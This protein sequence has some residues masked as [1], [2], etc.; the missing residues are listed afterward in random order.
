MKN[1]CTPPKLAP[2]FF[3]WSII[4]SIIAAA[5]AAGFTAAGGSRAEAAEAWP[6]WR[7]PRG[8]G[9]S[10]AAD[11]PISWAE[12]S[13]IKWKCPL[14]PWGASTPAIWDDAVFVTTQ[15][16]DERLLL[17]RIDA[18][19]GDIVW[20]R[21]VGREQT[22]RA[23]Q[24]RKAGEERR[25][26]KFHNTHNLATPS[27]VTDGQLVVCHWGNGLLAAYDFD[28]NK[29]WQ[30]NLQEEHGK[31]TIWW[32]HGNSPILYGDL[33]INV[34]MQDSLADLPGDP[35]P[36]Y[37]AAYHKRSGA[38]AWKVLRPTAATA[39]SCDSYT[40]PILR[41]NNKRTEM[42]VWGGQILDAYDPQT[43][44]KLWELTGLS[45]N[46]VIPSPVL[47]GDMIFAIQGMRQA[48]LAVRPS[49]DG[50][51]T[52]DDIVWK[53]DQGTSDS[54]SPIV[55]GE[56]LFMIS[57]D[58]VLRCFDPV[59][60][61]LLWKERLRGEYRASPIAAA[62]RLYF[63]NMKGLTT[64]V[65]ASRRFDKLTENQLDDEFVASPAVAHGCIYLRGKN[66]LYCIGR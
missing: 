31:Y 50:P 45:G 42:I 19:K 18:K 46:R 4:T 48:L 37:I 52:R 15:A 22:P 1:R 17:L 64:V 9:V 62:G 49:G 27:P 63:V 28:G 8:D 14:P 30:R 6:Q 34:C 32:G 2:T 11:L 51:R 43:G 65:S 33:V 16:D 66:A 20:T 21:E 53:F 13:G 10:S 36:S 38:P 40:T 47:Y 57:N 61:R 44:R 60:G 54:P 58:G 41:V 25:A 55:V 29:L 59:E 26:Q 23:A 3:L 24:L 35:S 56:Q 12:D 39:E 5:A 7:G